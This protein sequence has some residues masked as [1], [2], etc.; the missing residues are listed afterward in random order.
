Q[1]DQSGM[2]GSGEKAQAFYLQVGTILGR[3]GDQAGMAAWYRKGH[4]AA[5][6][7]RQG[8]GVKSWMQKKGIWQD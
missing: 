5:P 4:D 6:N 8:K 2:V 3:S 7:T 1:F